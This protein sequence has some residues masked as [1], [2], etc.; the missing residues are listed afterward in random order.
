[1]IKPELESA[2]WGMEG[3]THAN[4]GVGEVYDEFAIDLKLRFNAYL[5]LCRDGRNIHAEAVE[6]AG[7]TGHE[8]VLDIGCSDGSVLEKNIDPAHQGLLAGIDIEPTAEFSPFRKTRQE[9][10]NF[11]KGTM[12]TLPFADSSFDVSFALFSL[13]HADNPLAA[14]AEMSRI[15]KPGGKLI[16]ATSGHANKSKHRMIEQAIAAYLSPTMLPPHRFAARFNREIADHILPQLFPLEQRIHQETEM[17][18]NDRA[19]HDVYVESLSAMRYAFRP[20]I[21]GGQDQLW[22][23]IRNNVITPIIYQEIEDKGEFTDPV[24]RVV[25]VCRNT[26]PK[27]NRDESL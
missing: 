15:T 26:D 4:G 8:A 17:V 2:T 11:V 27:N 18:V 25:Y 13:Y 3:I 12:D 5:A 14:L 6:A 24:D 19:S 20:S 7:L 10:V 9:Q 1:M 16:I 23:S 22:S 21:K